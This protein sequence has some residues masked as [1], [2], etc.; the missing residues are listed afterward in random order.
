M[1][2]TEID[3]YSFKQ[4]LSIDIYKDIYCCIWK[5]MEINLK[6]FVYFPCS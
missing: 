3:F 6:Y 4:Y 2:N 1:K 5:V